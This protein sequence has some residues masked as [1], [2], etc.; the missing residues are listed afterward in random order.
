MTDIPRTGM[1]PRERE[2]RSQLARLVRSSGLIRGS[3]CVRKKVCGG[4]GCRCA[5][6]ERHEGLY[7]TQTKDGK[8]QQL[9]V[10]KSWEPRVR[11]WIA[12]YRRA[13]QLL[14]EISDMSWE[15]IRDRER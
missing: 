15:R 14:D 2:L 11:A 8:T 12:A 7:L 3:L 6:G 1:S 13:K 5:R 10:P 4:P 9:Y